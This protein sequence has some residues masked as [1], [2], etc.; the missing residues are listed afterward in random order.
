MINNQQ[1]RLLLNNLNKAI[2]TREALKVNWALEKLANELDYRLTP[3][4]YVKIGEPV[5]ALGPLI[6]KLW[7]QRSKQLEKAINNDDR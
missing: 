7:K 2:D 1:I 6:L 4:D 5:T 3:N